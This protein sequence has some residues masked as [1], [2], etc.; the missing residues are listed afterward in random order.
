VAIG[1]LALFSAI[2]LAPFQTLLKTVPLGLSDLAIVFGFGF[3]NIIFI[4]AAKW[5]F[6]TKHQIET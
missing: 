2:Y 3:V 4:E 6:I 1:F 5:Y